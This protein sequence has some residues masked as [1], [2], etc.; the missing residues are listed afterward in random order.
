MI[1]FKIF[2]TVEEMNYYF[3]GFKKDELTFISIET[4]SVDVRMPIS[5][6]MRKEEHFK[7]W[8]QYE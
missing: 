4:I 1:D 2:D 7:V 8:Y 5:D 6:S 3:S